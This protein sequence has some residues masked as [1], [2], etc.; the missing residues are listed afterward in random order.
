MRSLVQGGGIRRIVLAAGVYACVLSV[1]PCRAQGPPEGA[2]I[3]STCQKPV[4]GHHR[5]PGP[6]VGTLGYGKPGLYPGFQG[7]GL[8]YHLGYGYGGDALG[9]GI[10]GGYPFYGGPGYPHPWPTL[11]RFGAISPSPHFIGP[12]GPS[13]DHPNYFGGVGPLAP[14]QPV[15]IIEND[16]RDPTYKEGYGCFTG[17]IPYPETA[18][19]PFVTIAATGGLSSGVSPSSSPSAAPETAPAPGDDLNAHAAAQSLGVDAEPFVAPGLGTG[20]KVTR[21][22]PDSAGGKAGLRVGDV[23]YSINGYRTELP[24]HLT[25]IITNAAPD[26]VLKMSVRTGSDGQVRTTTVQLP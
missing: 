2:A 25:W 9:V 13:P 3:C 12:G 20:L 4:T 21:I 26:K 1:S 22:S 8:G 7:F 18:F 23:I 11:R 14:D 24:G 10:D 16:P 5:H 6:G 15:V 17:M 19:A